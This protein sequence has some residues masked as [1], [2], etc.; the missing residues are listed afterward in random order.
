MGPD[1]SA[2]EESDLSAVQTAKHALRERVW[3]LLERRGIASA[4]GR[5]PD[6]PGANL[7]AERL[8][9]L[10]LWRNA[11][12]IK[13]N[14]DEAQFPVRLRALQEGKR[15]YMAFPAMRSE[16]PFVLLDPAQLTQPLQTAATGKGGVEAGTLVGVESVEPV[17]LVIC[18]TVAV[19]KVGAR[20]GKGSGYSDI[21]VALLAEANLVSDTTPLVTTVHEAQVVDEP[22]P[23]TRHDFRVSTIV[24]PLHVHD[25]GQS[26]LPTLV[27]EHLTQDKIFT[28]PVL[29]NRR[30]AAS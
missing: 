6:F 21:E 9:Q 22:V 25:V 29:A 5:I 27:W 1:D 18:G 12:V 19:D 2:H 26:A 7:A 17:D 20:V 4:H 11:R 3:D 28:I 23:A 8:A 30:G 14:P 10:S 15:V 16:L 13:A 24:T